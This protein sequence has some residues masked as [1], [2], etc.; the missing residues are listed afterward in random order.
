MPVPTGRIRTPVSA[1]EK[2]DQLR[3]RLEKRFGSAILPQPGTGAQPEEEGGFRTGVRAIDALLPGGVPRRALS[4]WTGEGTCG[5]TGALRRVVE[6]ACAGGARVALVDA[7]LTLDAAAWCEGEA[8]ASDARLWVARPPSAGRAAEGAW[9][10][11]ALLRS[12]AFDLV[13]LD[14]PAPGPVEAHRLRALARETGAA[15]LVC[16][17]REGAGWRAD[18]KLEFHPGPAAGGGLRAGGGFRRR[19]GVRAAKGGGA[20]GGERETEL[21]HEPAHRLP[22]GPRAADRRPG[23]RG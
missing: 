7:T 5:R 4:L 11:E 10:A 12:G 6:E 8:G 13:V 17:G 19:A 18:L 9:V 23:S 15:L 2:L 16:S 3:A 20:R 1:A 22:S 21:V 14:G